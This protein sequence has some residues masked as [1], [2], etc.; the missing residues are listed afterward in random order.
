MQHGIGGI[1]HLAEQIQLLAQN[2][3]SQP[4][5][6]V[7]AG[8]EIDD[9]NVALLP[10]TMAAPNTLLDPLRIPRQIVV[11]DRLAKLQV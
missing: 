7:I 9:G 11:D 10:I 5:R 3:E 8:S 1:E 2:F 6:F 4:L